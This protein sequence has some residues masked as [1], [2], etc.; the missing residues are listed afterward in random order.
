M[1][2]M[3]CLLLL[4]TV[5]C[6][7][8]GLALKVGW[9]IFKIVLFLICFPGLILALIFGGAFII[10]LPLILIMAVLGCVAKA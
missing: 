9:G 4:A 6:K 5:F 7:L 2:T 3:F 10:A 1:I 8:L